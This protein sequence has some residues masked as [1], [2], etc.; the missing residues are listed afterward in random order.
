[1]GDFPNHFAVIYGINDLSTFIL[2]IYQKNQFIDMKEWIY[3]YLVCVF[4]HLFVGI[5]F[6]SF[7]IANIISFMFTG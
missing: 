6:S 3:L 1:M 7:F 5:H 4:Y 2:P